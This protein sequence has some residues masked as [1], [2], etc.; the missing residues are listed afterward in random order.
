[1]SSADGQTIIA[2]LQIEG[3]DA[4]G[5]MAGVTQQ[6]VT[7]SARTGE[8][9]HTLNSIPVRGGY[10]Q[11]LWASPS[12]QLLIIS[13]TEPG[14]TIGTFNL[15]HNAGTYR[16]GRYTAIPWSNRTFAAAW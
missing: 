10:Q 3:H 13:G 9:L 5:H 14:P 12:G 1:M 7:F 15:G 16:Q 6:L 2:V 11:I 8:F 4:T